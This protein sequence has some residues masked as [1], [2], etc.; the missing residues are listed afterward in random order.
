MET[1]TVFVAEFSHETNTFSDEPT[2]REEFQERREYFHDEVLDEL[3]DTNTT[4]GGGIEIADREGVTLHPSVAAAAMPSGKV[5]QKAYEFYTEQ[6]LS[7]L[8]ETADEVDGVFLSLHGA[9]VQQGGVDGEGPLIQ[10]V[11]D[12]VGADVPVIVTLDL[13]GNITETMINAADA[14]IAFES[15]P[16]TDMGMTGQRA[17]E[18][19]L[20]TIDGEFQPVMEIERPPVLPYGPKQ[21]TRA[22]PMADIME[23]ARTLEKQDDILKVNVFPGFHQADIPSMG[24]SIPVV[25]DGRTTQAQRIARELAERVWE[26]RDEFVAEFP[27]PPEAVTSA[28]KLI[29]DGQTEDGPIVLADLGDNPGGGGATDGTTVLRELIDQGVENSGFALIHDPEVVDQ[30]VTAGVGENIR[31]TVGGKKDDLHGE[32]IEDLEL[33]V[34]AITDGQFRNT[35]PM[36]TGTRNDLGRAVRAQIGG[37]VGIELILVDNRIQPLDAEVWRHLGIQPERLDVL[38][39]KSTNHYRADYEP[40]ASEVIPVDS[41]GLVAVNPKQFDHDNIQRPKFPIDEMDDSAYP[42]WNSN[43]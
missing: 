24:F 14:L 21:N 39:V 26:R 16:H 18:L 8:K 15:Y 30:A 43:S 35:G 37:E 29:K 32:P 42:D 2:R 6:I 19:L 10:A 23:D 1:P 34:K 27:S 41:P 20:D 7:D 25:A 33:Y 22:G 31:A 5:T 17:M 11:R 3:R 36:G 12:V 4:I 13:H 28:K 38:V 40:M 9:M